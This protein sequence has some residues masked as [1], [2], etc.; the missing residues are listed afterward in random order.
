MPE[1]STRQ[2]TTAK[3]SSESARRRNS[4]ENNGL[5]NAVAGLAVVAAL[6][7]VGAALK[8]QHDSEAAYNRAP[9]VTLANDILKH[10]KAE[11]EPVILVIKSGVNVRKTPSIVEP[12][13]QL[14][15]GNNGNVDSRVNDDEALVVY[16]PIV[17]TE[18]DDFEGAG[19]HDGVRTWYGFRDPSAAK[20]KQGETAEELANSLVW[21]A[22]DTSLT[23][24]KISVFEDPRVGVSS[25]T[26]TIEAAF[27]PT[28]SSFNIQGSDR[29]AATAMEMS[30]ADIDVLK[31]TLVP[32]S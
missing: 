5:R 30:A 12:D 2:N 1:K 25:E 23:G 14:I 27:D 11:V 15:F 13:H 3:P 16:D 19:S 7:G 17:R 26:G 10:G 18:S 20:A 32:H 28:T 8:H 6:G 22:A 31:T 29:E 21:V 4:R 9:E 24:S